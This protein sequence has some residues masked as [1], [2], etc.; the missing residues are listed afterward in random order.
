MTQVST[1]GEIESHESV[2]RSHD[3]LVD[4]QICWASAQALYI[5]S[6]FLCVET[7][8]SQ[9]TGLTRQ[10]DGIDMLVSAIVASPGIALGVL[11]GHGRAQG[12]KD[13]SRCEVFRGDQD[14][15]LSLT[16]DFSFL[17]EYQTQNI[18]SIEAIK[19][20]HHDFSNF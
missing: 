7:K 3:G 20:A 17:V 15:G 5:D 9:G 10:L 1:M 19:V 2:M 12:I 8:G 6:P 11:V 13:C 16:L 4:L 18:D 14:N